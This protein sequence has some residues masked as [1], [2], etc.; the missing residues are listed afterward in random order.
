MRDS[1][2]SL[3]EYWRFLNEANEDNEDWVP[4]SRPE[5]VQ[6]FV[7][8]DP[9]YDV[10]RHWVEVVDN[11][12]AADL[13]VKVQWNEPPEAVI[14]VNIAKN[15]RGKGLGETLL[16]TAL[17]SLADHHGSV[18]VILS[19]GN[20]EV[21]PFAKTRGFEGQKM[22]DLE[23]SLEPLE[24]PQV[25]E[26]YRIASAGKDQLR[27][28][29]G[30]WTEIFGSSRRLEE[31]QVMMAEGDILMDIAAAFYANE[32]VGFSLAQM[33]PRLNP[34]EGWVAQLGVRTEHRLKGV[35]KA[36]LLSS[37]LWLRRQSCSTATI[38]AMADNLP[39]LGLYTKLGFKVRRVKEKH[40]VCRRWPLWLGYLRREGSKSNMSQRGK[41]SP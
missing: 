39:A 34:N 3:E 31:L 21:V 5:G 28:L 35:G 2:L 15:S 13:T 8:S 23:R 27:E 9:L 1:R 20:R 38:N 40:L 29:T 24:K 32:T 36:L 17:E 7:F 22:I 18:K 33:A 41:R 19:P 4:Y 26:G 14:E 10:D 25:P 30:L 37:L 6:V 16:N 11:R 12:L